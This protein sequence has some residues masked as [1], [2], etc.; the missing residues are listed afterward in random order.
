[1]SGFIDRLVAPAGQVAV[2]AAQSMVKSAGRNV[3]F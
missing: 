2:P 1:L 3:P